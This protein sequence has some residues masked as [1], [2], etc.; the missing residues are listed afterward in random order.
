MCTR[1]LPTCMIGI[2]CVPHLVRQ[3]RVLDPPDLE[4]PDG[5][6]LPSTGATE[7]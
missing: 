3:K 5:C 4:L 2:I 1:F 6:E 7:F